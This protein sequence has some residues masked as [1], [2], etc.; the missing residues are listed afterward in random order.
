MEI[1]SLPDVLVLKIFSYLSVK[2]VCRCW[3]RIAYDKTLWKDID[4]TRFVS[5][6]LRKVWKFYRSRLSDV[7]KSL[8][9][10]G[11]Y[12]AKS[13]SER[14]KKQ[15][16]SDALLEEISTACPNI[17]ELQLHRFYLEKMSSS[18]L[19]RSL[20]HLKL[21]E[22]GWPLGWL[23]DADL[24]NLRILDLGKTTRIGDSEISSIVK[25]TNL[26]ELNLEELYRIS[27]LGVKELA[28]NCTL[29]K[30][31]K[32]TS[33]KVADLGVHF[34][35]RNMVSLRGLDL[36]YTLISDSAVDD[37]I[38]SLPNLKSFGVAG[39]AVTDTGVKSL[40][41]SKNGRNL[42][43]LDISATKITDDALTYIADKL[44]NLEDLNLAITKVSREAINNMSTQL[45]KLS[46]VN[47]GRGVS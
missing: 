14:Q 44:I 13:G 16:L 18:R 23:N 10:V 19:P 21:R 37:I 20:T 33:A 15:L 28:E 22:C 46:H 8:K 9:M 35:C 43:Q 6:D 34:I 30:V 24:P 12:N 40:C 25:F 5:L 29:L 31:L 32:L 38:T 3:R 36:S 17:E 4:M 41:Y 47:L 1:S 42:V 45:G 26:E 27:D 7:L 11:Y 2:E 39:T